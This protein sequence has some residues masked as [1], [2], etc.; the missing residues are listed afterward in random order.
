MEEVLFCGLSYCR[1]VI[2]GREEVFSRRGRW[3]DGRTAAGD[4]LTM[5]KDVEECSEYMLDGK[6]ASE[7]AEPGDEG[8]CLSARRSQFK[9]FNP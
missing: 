3:M 5:V 7:N 1:A 9:N 6:G 8:T 2:G 4:D